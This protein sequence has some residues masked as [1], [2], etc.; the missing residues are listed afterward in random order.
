M[1]TRHRLSSRMLQWLKR[2]VT[3]AESLL[4]SRQSSCIACGAL[5]SGARELALCDGC[6]AAVPW[7]LQV[8]CSRCGR[9]EVCTDCSRRMDTYFVQNR[10]AVSY[11]PLM[12]EWLAMYKY[13]GHEK[14]R[15]LLGRMLLHA[16]H[17]HKTAAFPGSPSK[18]ARELI[19][20]V[21]LSGE[22]RLERGFNQAQQLAED[23]G[24]SLSIPVI[25]LLVR[26]RHTAKQSFKTR[27]DRLDDLQGVFALLPESQKA[28]QDLLHFSDI[29]LY[30]VDDVYTTGSTLNECARTVKAE[31]PNVAVYGIGWAR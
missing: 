26:V 1:E 14:L 15:E 17:L 16:Y 7:I 19:T 23:L 30:I 28:L 22:R 8:Q 9:P 18:G 29:T 24:G 5:Y 4:S 21:P 31:L 27:G 10:S 3:Q 6:A 11:S 2:S 12:K 20:Y 13:R 25:P